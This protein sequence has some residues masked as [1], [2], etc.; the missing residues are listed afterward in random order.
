MVGFD[1]DKKIIN[2]SVLKQKETPGLGTKIKEPKFK[3]QFKG[4][5]PASFKMAVKKD[6]GEVDAISA[7][8]ITSRAFCEAVNKAY[9]A[10]LKGGE[11]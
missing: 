1:T 3:D 5:D 4:K 2:I 8:T 7:A 11:K 10:L 6:G 9:Q